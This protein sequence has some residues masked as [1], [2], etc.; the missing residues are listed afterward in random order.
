MLLTISQADFRRLERYLPKGLARDT[1]NPLDRAAGQLTRMVLAQSLH[2]GQKI[3]MDAIATL[4][5]A[6]RT[7]VR[8][9]LRLLETEGLVTSLP[10]RGFIVR[11]LD[12]EE[13]EHLYQARHCIEAFV[14]RESFRN[15]D[16]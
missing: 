1:G 6:S 2:P 14:A 5:G 12:P 4:I 9:A 16:A 10:N 7:P 13:T 8:E 15:R 11:R 3:P